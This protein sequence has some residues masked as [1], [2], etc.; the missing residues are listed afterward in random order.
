MYVFFLKFACPNITGSFEGRPAS[1]N[2]SSTI[3]SNLLSVQNSQSL[4]TLEWTGEK[5][6]KKISSVVNNNNLSNSVIKLDASRVS[7]VYG[8][9]STVQPISLVLN[10][11]IKY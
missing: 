4:F 10:H 11:I 1:Y 3:N 5:M 8:T 7:T 9:S 6:L 2:E